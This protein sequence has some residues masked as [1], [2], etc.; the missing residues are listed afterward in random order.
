MQVVYE[1]AA[2]DLSIDYRQQPSPPLSE[3]D[4]QWVQHL[5]LEKK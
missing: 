2:L 1:A 5:L 3:E 4:Y